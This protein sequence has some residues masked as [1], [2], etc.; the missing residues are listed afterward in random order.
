MTYDEAR[1]MFAAAV[2]A[3]P[4]GEIAR[5]HEKLRGRLNSFPVGMRRE[6][7]EAARPLARLVEYYEARN[8]EL[9]LL[10]EIFDRGD[11]GLSVDVQL[12]RLDTYWERVCDYLRALGPNTEPVMAPSNPDPNWPD[13]S[14]P[15]GLLGSTER[16]AA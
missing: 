13:C 4:K 7:L 8:G 1:H 5:L 15:A 6:A 14:A 3:I 2:A 10:E 9:R 16:S 11:R 12:Q